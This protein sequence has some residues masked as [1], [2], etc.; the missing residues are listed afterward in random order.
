MTDV[1]DAK[2]LTANLE[3]SQRASVS[4]LLTPCLNGFSAEQP[5]DQCVNILYTQITRSFH[6]ERSFWAGTEMA[7]TRREARRE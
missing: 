1:S 4:G 2:M 7:E 3:E 6:M 5:F